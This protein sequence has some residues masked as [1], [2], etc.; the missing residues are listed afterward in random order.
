MQSIVD[1]ISKFYPV[2]RDILS[3]FP[4]PILDYFFLILSF[5]IGCCLANIIIKAL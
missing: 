1:G 3:S 5:L 2:L 4:F